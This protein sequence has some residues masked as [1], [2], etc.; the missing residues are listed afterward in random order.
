MP[1]TVNVVSAPSG[2]TRR[3]VLAMIKRRA[4]AAGCR[5]RRAATRFPGDGGGTAY[6][7][8]GGGLGA[9]AADRRTCVPATEPPTRP[10]HSGRL[11]ILGSAVAMAHRARDQVA[12]A[13]G[14]GRR[15]TA[16]DRAAGDPSRPA[17]ATLVSMARRHRRPKRDRLR[18]HADIEALHDKID[19]LGSKQDD[20]NRLSRRSALTGVAGLGVAVLAWMRS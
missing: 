8:N 17:A 11:A 15:T 13:R 16:R 2:R 3:V 4:A 5:R 9:R 18:V 7:S 20:Q 1:A 10:G 12:A 14:L 19:Q 6:L